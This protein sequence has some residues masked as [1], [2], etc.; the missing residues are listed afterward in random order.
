MALLAGM[1]LLC[2]RYLAS[3]RGLKSRA[4]TLNILMAITVAQAVSVAAALVYIVASGTLATQ[5]GDWAANHVFVAGALMI[6]AISLVSL[7]AYWRTAA[8]S[9][10]SA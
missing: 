2:A 5:K 3:D 9:P 6:G 8:A 10:V 7:L 4:S 1:A